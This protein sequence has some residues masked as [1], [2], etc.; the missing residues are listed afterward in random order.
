[1]AVKYK[2]GLGRSMAALFQGATQGLPSSESLI[3]GR[4]RKKERAE[5]REERAAARTFARDRETRANI[6]ARDAAEL[7][8]M[9][10]QQEAE[11]GRGFKRDQAKLDRESAEAIARA[12]RDS[13]ERVARVRSGPAHRRGAL[14]EQQEKNRVL[15]ATAKR[16][17]PA[18]RKALEADLGIQAGQE[19]PAAPPELLDEV[20]VQQKALQMAR[21]YIAKNTTVPVGLPTRGSAFDSEQRQKHDA[22]KADRSRFNNYLNHILKMSQSDDGGGYPYPKTAT[23]L[24]AEIDRSYKSRRSPSEETI[25]RIVDSYSGET[26]IEDPKDLEDARGLFV[27]MFNRALDGDM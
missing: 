18:A 24:V 8:W 10:S 16:L 3:A 9:R 21:E 6:A 15:A 11:R 5:D 23:I 17:L 12:R 7:A 19:G 4:R 13:A 22:Q 25:D 2:S 20:A 27:Q 1:M 26:R 14:L